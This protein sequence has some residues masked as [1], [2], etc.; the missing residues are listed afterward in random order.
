VGWVHRVG[1]AQRSRDR[2]R[3]EGAT[4]NQRTEAAAASRERRQL[5]TG[6][7]W[8]PS[9]ERRQ[10]QPSRQKM[11]LQPSRQRMQPS[12]HRM[13]RQP[14]RQRRQLQDKLIKDATAAK[15]DEVAT[16]AQQ[17]KCATAA[18]QIKG[19]ATAAQQ[20]KGAADKRCNCS[21]EDGGC[22]CSQTDERG[23][24]SRTVQGSCS[25]QLDPNRPQVDI[26]STFVTKGR[27]ITSSNSNSSGGSS[28]EWI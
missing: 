16:T 10:L 9:R 14:S 26:I 17:I 19:A 21:Q 6:C 8:Q 23:S 22:R 12:R 13:Q 15:L 4:A 24:R 28:M 11:Q 18:Q 2:M 7:S 3:R 20:I 25:L 27:T 5:H 1:W